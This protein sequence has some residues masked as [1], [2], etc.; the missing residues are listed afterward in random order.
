MLCAAELLL[1]VVE[2][3]TINVHVLH[4]N[5]LCRCLQNTNTWN[6]IIQHEL[7]NSSMCVMCLH[8]SSLNQA[9]LVG[10]SLSEPHTSEKRGVI[11]HAQKNTTK[12]GKLT[13]ATRIQR[14]RLQRILIWLVLSS[15][16][17]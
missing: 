2:I 11:V 9:V 14:H 16:P 10:A 5:V 3:T 15:M 8:A 1:L 7:Q 17:R 4:T 12:I 13:R 6:F